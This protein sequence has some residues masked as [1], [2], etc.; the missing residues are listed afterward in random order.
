[1]SRKSILSFPFIPPFIPILLIKLKGIV[2]SEWSVKMKESFLFFFFF[3]GA[4][5]FSTTSSSPERTLMIN[6]SQRCFG[7][8]LLQLIWLPKTRISGEILSKLFC[9]Q[10]KFL[11]VVV[12]NLRDH[13]YYIILYVDAVVNRFIN[14]CSSFWVQLTLSTILP[15][16]AEWK[17]LDNK[18][19]G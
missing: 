2:K 6:Q 17:S 19:S 14:V 15:N 11:E 7:L 12:V 16:V 5:T 13:I 1:M 10:E 3:R 8:C 4:E 18:K 9:R